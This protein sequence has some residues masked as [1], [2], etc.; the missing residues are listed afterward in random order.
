MTAGTQAVSQQGVVLTRPRASQPN[1]R[2]QP[3]TKVVM[4]KSVKTSWMASK[5]FAARPKPA[6]AERGRNHFRIDT[7]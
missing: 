3:K 5:P 4:V 2:A 7:D 6:K 1:S